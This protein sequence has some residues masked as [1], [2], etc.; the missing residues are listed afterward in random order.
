MFAW[1]GQLV[2]RR[3]WSLLAGT[4]VFVAIAGISGVSVFSQLKGGGFDD[5]NAEAVQAREL[6]AQEFDAGS[7]DLVLLVTPEDGADSSGAEAA[8]QA[9]TEELADE[10]GVAQALSYWSTGNPTLRSDNRDQALVLVRLSG[11]EEEVEVVA[12]RIID[13]Y[14][15]RDGLEIE[16][17]GPA[18]L[19]VSLGGIIGEDLA[20]AEAIAVPLT[21]IL[22]TLVFGSVISGL[23][24]IAVGAIAVLG[25]F[26]SLFLVSQATDVSIFAINL[27]TA[28]GL[29]LAIDYSLLIVS[30]FREELAAGRSTEEAI[31]RTVH[32]AGR[33]VAFSALIV[34]VALSALL[35]FPLYFLRSFAYGGIAVV[36]IAM[37]GALV[38]LPALLSVLGARVDK[39]AVGKGRRPVQPGTGM[40]HRIATTVMRRPVLVG[41]PVV[42]LLVLLATPLLGV[43]FGLPDDRYLPRDQAVRVVGDTLRTEFGGGGASALSVVLPDGSPEE[44]AALAEEISTLEAVAAVDTVT[45]SYADGDQVSEPDPSA[46]RFANGTGT[47]LEV[48]SDLEPI[49]PEGEQLVRDIRELDTGTEFLVAG[50]SADLADSKDSIF[51]L[52]PLALAIIAVATFVLLFLMTGSI[53]I[54]LQALILNVL[55]LGAVFGAMVWIFQDG[56]LSGLLDFTSTG[57]IDTAIPMLV[58]C[59]AFGL[60]MDYEVFLISRIKEEYDTNGGDNT[61]A[62]ANG[63]QRTGRIMTAA[64]GVL[65]ITF[66]AFALTSQVNTI[67]LFGLAMTL[68]IL[69]DATLVR[70]LLVPSFL[71]L[72]GDANWWAPKPLRRIY[73]RVG[74]S[75]AEPSK[76]AVL[77]RSS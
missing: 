12:E 74:M 38:A 51:S 23:L 21:L 40:W 75:E 8:G 27:T 62:V 63:L 50:Q 35:I 3:R 41:T 47:Y 66:I 30:R 28:L 26:L 13:G 20:I 60:S 19:G 46:D 59:I 29:G 18:A 69:L 34:A 4:V 76:P 67:K 77:S 1:L 24:P 11:S 58:F 55:S 70:G 49:S 17:G 5:A 2:Y 7:P 10:D 64:A 33:T 56:N 73:E 53:L 48:R 15:S 16:T 72:G 9:L 43:S 42:L 37:L 14:T 36:L 6:L 45:G 61:A 54:P 22:L 25:T 71:R 31:A 57:T 52:V 44:A 39:L 68:A 32:T 65:S